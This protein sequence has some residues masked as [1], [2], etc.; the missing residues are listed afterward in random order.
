[1]VLRD[2]CIAMRLVANQ[3]LSQVLQ[4]MPPDYSQEHIVIVL[5]I[6][7]PTASINEIKRRLPGVKVTYVRIDSKLNPFAAPPSVVP[8]GKASQLF[9]DAFF[10]SVGRLKGMLT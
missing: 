10:E 6:P 2:I 7:E 1:M 8:K 5:W 4:V 9:R 3:R